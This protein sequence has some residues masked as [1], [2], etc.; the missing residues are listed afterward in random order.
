MHLGTPV[1]SAAAIAIL[2]LNVAAVGAQTP[3]VSFVEINDAVRGRFFDAATT[4]PDP[5]DGNTLVIRF[6]S[7]T[8]P[9]T[10]KAN[11]FRASTAAFSHLSAMDTISFRIVPPEGYYVS[12]VTYRQLG[13]GS[14]VRTGKAAGGTHWVVGD[15]ASQ[16]ALFLTN[17]DVSGSIEL[18][19][20]WPE[21][22]V[23]IS[24]G[25]HVFSTPQLGSASLSITS[26]SVSV[27]LTAIEPAIEPS[28]SEP[29]PLPVLDAPAVLV[30]DPAPPLN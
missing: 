3:T 6:N 8:D 2:L 29:E 16:V 28:P 5:A 9:A 11:D 30:E 15:D 21:L 23:S 20:Y 1:T 26:A 13:S 17:P 7:G 22:P 14:I 10:W 27:Q 25:L 4:A 24:A 19:S 18:T 12:K